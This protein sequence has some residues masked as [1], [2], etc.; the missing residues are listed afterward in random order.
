M[1]RALL[2]LAALAVMLAACTAVEPRKSPPSKTPQNAVLD[3]PDVM[4]ES[5]V[6]FGQRKDGAPLRT[7]DPES[8]PDAQPRF[9][10]IKVDGNI[11]PYEVDGEFYT[12]VDDYRGFR[13]RGKASWYG[14]KFHG[15]KTSNGEIY[16]LYGMSA[17]HKTL[18]IPIYVRVTNV[19]NGRQ[20]VVRVNDR[21]PFH[22]ERIIDLSYAAAVKL[23]FAKQGTATVEIEVIDTDNMR[24]ASKD[25]SP[26]YYLQVGA[27]R[28]LDSATKLRARLSSDL[29]YPI[30]I[31]SSGTN[32]TALHRVRVGPFV[33]YPS[34]QAAKKVLKQRW[35]GEPSLVVEEDGS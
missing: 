24:S 10:I 30:D 4:G 5:D 1:T 3:V 23:G 17:A 19:D 13:Q 6:P 11:S 8:I 21:G 22:S 18:P 34:A 27:F 20:T 12:L 14:T 35:A 29:Q 15:R 32:K 31:A 2:F 9:D 16:S 28:Q 26:R 7:L 33:D 25:S